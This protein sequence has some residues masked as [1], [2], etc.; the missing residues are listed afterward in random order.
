MSIALTSQQRRV[1]VVVWG[2]Y[3]FYYLG[4]LNLSSA[5]PALSDSLGVSRAEV[6]SL[7]TVFFWAY[8]LG[9][10]VNGELG[11]HLKPRYIVAVGLLI[12]ALS[13][14]L[15]SLQTT[16]L[17]L[18]ILWGINGFAQASGWAPMMRIL[19]ERLDAHQRQRI[20]TFF[21]MSFQVGNAITWVVAGFLVF[22]GGWQMAF[23]LPG[24]ILL[25]VLGVW[26]FS[27]TGTTAVAADERA[28]FRWT[29]VQ[30][31]WQQLG[32]LLF[33]AA[34]IG[35][36]HT[37]MAIWLPTYIGDIGL[38]PEAFTGTVAGIMA[39]VGIVGMWASGL[40]LA[41]F[42]DLRFVLS[43]VTLAL[44]FV[45]SASVFL[46]AWPQLFMIALALIVSSGLAGLLLSSI[47]ILLAREDRV[48]SAAGALT[49]VFGLGGGLA[50]FVVGALLESSNWNAVFALW[51]GCALLALLLMQTMN[52]KNEVVA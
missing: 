49:A 51:S 17:P 18:L 36:I 13:N 44:I 42:C 50:G 25:G 30:R 24:F 34:A 39:L 43:V 21:P 3:A 40:L 37:G 9:Q 29:D 12:V 6:G 48:S 27:D 52:N 10:I 1:V 31:E 4:R 22:W 26:W 7:G 16:L 33:A 32:L 11:N 23:W 45:L 5:I 46:S 2:T 38:F 15:F 20:S 41:R 19:S 47:P 8:T 14:V 28:S 35:F